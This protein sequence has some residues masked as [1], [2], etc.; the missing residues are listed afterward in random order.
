MAEPSSE[1]PISTVGRDA[2]RS[3]PHSRLRNCRTVAAS[4]VAKPTLSHPSPERRLR[5]QRESQQLGRLIDA[6][7][8]DHVVLR[9]VHHGRHRNSALIRRQF[10]F[11]G[12]FTGLRVE[13]QKKRITRVRRPAPGLMYHSDQGCTYASEDD[14]TRLAQHGLVCSMSRRGN[15]GGATSYEGAG[16]GA[17]YPLKKV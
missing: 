17:P 1:R 16:G 5:E 6:A 4:R 10:E 8:R 7:N 9:A 2:P 12:D 3:G 14:Q 15:C 13:R 11:R